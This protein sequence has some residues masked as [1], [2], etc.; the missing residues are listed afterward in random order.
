MEFQIFGLISSFLSKRRLWVVLYGKSSQ[1][2]L[3]NAGVTQGSM[4]SPTLFPLHINDLPGNVI[5]N[6]AIYEDDTT[7]YAKC[8]Q[9][10]DLW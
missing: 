2:Y 7:F 10:S 4:F 3:V 6:M 9:A 1:E 8:D 5:C